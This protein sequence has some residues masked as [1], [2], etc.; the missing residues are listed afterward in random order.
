MLIEKKYTK[1][2]ENMRSHAKII[3][4][5]L[6]N[7]KASPIEMHYFY[8]LIILPISLEILWVNYF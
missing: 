1:E 8:D 6:F 3:L 7:Q 4:R 2:R 5:I